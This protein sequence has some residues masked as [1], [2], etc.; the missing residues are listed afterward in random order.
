MAFLQSAPP[1][2]P[3]FRAPPVVMWLLALLVALH[4]ARIIQPPVRSMFLVFEYGLIPARYSRAFLDTHPAGWWERALPFVTHMGLHDSFTHLAINSLFLLA[5][6]PIVARRF[7]APLFLLFFLVCGVA[8][9][10]LY[11]GMNWNAAEPMIG[12]S[13]AI[14]GLMAAA[15]RMLPTQL[16]WAMPGETPLAPVW[17][18]Q[19]LTFALIWAAVNFIGGVMGFGIGGEPGTIAWQAHLGGFL[20]GLLLADVFDW[21]RPRPLVRSLGDG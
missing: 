5:F 12:A 7:G 6:G 3:I 11:V 19:V 2:Q 14:S 13:G 1:R 21:L 18:R 17:S 9:A 4:V 8:G 10:G 20:A 15:M 16:P